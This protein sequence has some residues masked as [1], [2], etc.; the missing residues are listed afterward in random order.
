MG[1]S[2]LECAHDVV[3]GMC[4]KVSKTMTCIRRLG[5]HL[6][7]MFHRCRG[8]EAVG[9]HCAHMGVSGGGEW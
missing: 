6:N 2:W 7:P 8:P 9:W 3:M 1:G 5:L 4:S